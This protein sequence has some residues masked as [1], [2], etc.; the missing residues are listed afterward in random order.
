MEHDVVP[1][2]VYITR[3]GEQ[4]RVFARHCSCGH[5]A[6]SPSEIGVVEAMLAHQRLVQLPTRLGPLLGPPSWAPS[7]DEIN[8][9]A[10]YVPWSWSGRAL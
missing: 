10:P 2:V 5:Q 3:G 9:R 1:G 6:S 4:R 7:A 8:A